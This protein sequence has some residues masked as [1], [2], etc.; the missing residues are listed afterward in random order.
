MWWADKV[1]YIKSKNCDEAFNKEIE[2]GQVTHSMLSLAIAG[3][4]SQ[5]AVEAC[6][7]FEDVDFIDTT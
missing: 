5:E 1:S 3:V 7:S 4:Q 6:S 2:D